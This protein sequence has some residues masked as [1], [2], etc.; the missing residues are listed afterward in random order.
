MSTGTTATLTRVRMVGN[1]STYDE[2]D[3]IKP[4][5]SCHHGTS[6]AMINSVLTH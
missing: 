5:S 2:R 6:A 4:P 1:V 3:F